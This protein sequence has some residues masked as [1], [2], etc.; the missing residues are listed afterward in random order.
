[1]VERG[2]LLAAQ[3]ER[4]ASAFASDLSLPSPSLQRT[5][6]S[7][8]PRPTQ[9]HTHVSFGATP[10]RTLVP[11]RPFIFRWIPKHSTTPL[12]QL[13]TSRLLR[14]LTQRDRSI[15][16]ILYD[17]RYLTTLQIRHLFFPSTRSTQLRI[18]YLM[19]HGLIYRWKMSEPPGITRRP[20][21]LLIS[22]RGARLMADLHGESPWPYIRRAKHA[23]DHCWHVVHDLEANGFFVDLVLASRLA[24]K[25]GL[26]RWVGEE[27]CRFER[28]LNTSRYRLRLPVATPDGVGAYLVRGKVIRFDLEWDRG[29]ASMSRLRQKVRTAVR[30]FKA[31]H[32]ARGANVLYV[33]STARREESLHAVIEDEFNSDSCRF[34]TTTV[35][36][37]DAEGP[38]GQI[39]GEATPLDDD[40][41]EDTSIFAPRK[42]KARPLRRQRLTQLPVYGETTLTI[43]DCIGRAQWWDRRPGGGEV[44]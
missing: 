29:T 27:T 30:Y 28:R 25:E 7:A 3:E 18:Q 9:D 15:L 10:G 26:L 23:R 16:Q 32:D 44:L 38:L 1:M 8:K 36:R 24:L 43:S 35:G 41:E 4:F 2:L 31:V 34:W 11:I 42:R 14:S 33:V 13:Q 6:G 19:G 22:P 12:T 21:L 17:Y 37:L 20:S 5:K 39:W 40:D